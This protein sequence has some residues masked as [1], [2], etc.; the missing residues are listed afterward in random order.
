MKIN[1]HNI[2]K[3]SFGYGPFSNK[4]YENTAK[5]MINKNILKEDVLKSLQNSYLVFHKALKQ[6]DNNL[7]KSIT[8]TKF[9]NY[10]DENR[11]ISSCPQSWVADNYNNSCVPCSNSCLTCF[12]INFDNCNSCLDGNY[13]LNFHCHLF[14]Y[15]FY[16]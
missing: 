4:S 12:G 5:Y 15:Q 11:C 9:G 1:L 6:K 8:T 7:I 14:L 16:Y 2:P 13:L 10:L 3:Y